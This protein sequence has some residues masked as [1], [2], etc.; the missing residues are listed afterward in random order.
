[1]SIGGDE[2]VFGFEVAVDDACG[3]ETFA[4]FDNLGCVETRPVAAES[5]PTGKLGGKVASGVKVLSERGF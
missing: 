5:T 1:M 2:N 4:A 3:M